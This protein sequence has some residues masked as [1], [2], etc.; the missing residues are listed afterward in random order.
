MQNTVYL[1]F[2]TY[3]AILT[4]RARGRRLAYEERLEVAWSSS[5][6]QSSLVRAAR[7]MAPSPP[8]SSAQIGR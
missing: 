6:T 8:T 5:S 2:A 7:V 1:G 3:A 4:P